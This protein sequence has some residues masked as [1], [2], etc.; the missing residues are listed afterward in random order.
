MVA[1]AATG[2]CRQGRVQSVPGVAGAAR[3]KGLAADPRIPEL[4][5]RDDVEHGWDVQELRRRGA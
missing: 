2:A 4:A 5:A 1:G 3:Q